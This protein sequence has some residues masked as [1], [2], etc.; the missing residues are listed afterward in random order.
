MTEQI[1]KVG[2]KVRHRITGDKG[3]TYRSD[4]HDLA[5]VFYKRNQAIHVNEKGFEDGCISPT[6]ELIECPK[7]MIKKEAKVF[8]Y[9]EMVQ[10]M[11]KNIPFSKIPSFFKTQIYD[12][13]IPVTVTW[14]EQE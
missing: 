9:L 6:I 10:G 1:F 3:E 12:E 8:V 11:A 5:V 14:E 4:T 13:L 7:K 2:D